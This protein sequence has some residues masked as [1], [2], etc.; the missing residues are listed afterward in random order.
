AQIANPGDLIAPRGMT[1]I[2]A[3]RR[4]TVIEAYRTNGAIAGN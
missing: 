1:P 4:S 2:D 3:E